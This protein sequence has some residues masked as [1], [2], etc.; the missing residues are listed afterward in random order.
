[1]PQHLKEIFSKYASAE[2]GLTLGQL[3]S[4]TQ[5]N[6]NAGDVVGWMAG[7]VGSNQGCNQSGCAY[8]PWW[9][10]F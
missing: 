2:G 5:G 3:L 9:A 6:W 7:A 4:M 1:M 10:V 8:P